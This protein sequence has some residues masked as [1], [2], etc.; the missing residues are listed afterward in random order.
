MPTAY[1]TG[2]A[3]FVGRHLTEQ[4]VEQDWKVTAFCRPTD[5]VDLLPAGVVVA[6][7]DVT[8]PGAVLDTLAPDTDAVFHLAANTSTWSKNRQA[9]WRVNVDGPA[10]AYLSAVDRRREAQNLR[11]LAPAAAVN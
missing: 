4:L 6:R 8:E 2:A 9:Q 3:G 1:I 11:P 10:W 5:R 7:G